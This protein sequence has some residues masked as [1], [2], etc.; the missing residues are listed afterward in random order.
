M[1]ERHNSLTSVQAGGGSGASQG[2]EILST[3]EPGQQSGGGKQK[4]S[5]LPKSSAPKPWTPE[6][7]MQLL[8]EIITAALAFL[9][10]IFTLI[11]VWRSFPLIGNST[12][13][14]EARDL[15]TIMLGLAGVVVGYYFGRV[16]ADAHTSQANARADE[17]LTQNTN[18]KAKAQEISANLDRI[19]DNCTPAMSGD[20]QQATAS[21]LAQLRSLRDE[22]HDLTGPA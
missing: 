3:E 20:S 2:H 6:L 22:V 11:I 21:H 1:N 10:I 18:L 14:A 15:L 12:K 5:F 13:V 19:I 9:I 17:V 4:A 7:R 8:K 16:S